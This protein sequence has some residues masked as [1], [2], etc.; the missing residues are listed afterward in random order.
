MLCDCYLNA[1]MECSVGA[2]AAQL[3]SIVVSHELI[4][5]KFG[6]ARD[7]LKLDIHLNIGY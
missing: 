1:D 6:Q 2:C 4:V 5:N 7:V 3:K